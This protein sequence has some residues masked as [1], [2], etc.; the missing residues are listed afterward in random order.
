MSWYLPVHR[1]ITGTAIVEQAQLVAQAAG[2]TSHNPDTEFFEAI[3]ATPDRLSVSC[4]A[5]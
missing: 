4:I 2:E 3:S 5:N 1:L